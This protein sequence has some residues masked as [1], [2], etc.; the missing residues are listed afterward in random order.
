MCL[1]V[2]TKLSRC[3]GTHGHWGIGAL[4]S[5]HQITQPVVFFFTMQFAFG[6]GWVMLGHHAEE[7][8][9]LIPLHGRDEG[10]INIVLFVFDNTNLTSRIVVSER[11]IQ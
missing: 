6:V 3:H 10:T 11:S 5:V 2:V 7:G 4:G 9:R 8:G 1:E